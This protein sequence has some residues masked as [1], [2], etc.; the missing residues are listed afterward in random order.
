MEITVKTTR[1]TLLAGSASLACTLAMPSI[2]RAAGAEFVY[3]FGVDLPPSH[4]TS[5]WSQ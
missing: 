2:A 5:I 1:R 3:K 4:P